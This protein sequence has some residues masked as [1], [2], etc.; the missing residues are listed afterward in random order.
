MVWEVG[1]GCMKRQVAVAACHSSRLSLPKTITVP[2]L[3]LPSIMSIW[4][5]DRASFRSCLHDKNSLRPADTLDHT[6]MLS[7]VVVES[8]RIGSCGQF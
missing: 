8:L 1:G 4:A 3:C 5:A 7:K 2:A 6:Q